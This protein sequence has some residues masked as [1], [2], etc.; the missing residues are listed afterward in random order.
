MRLKAVFA[1]V[2]SALLLVQPIWSQDAPQTAP[3]S[4]DDSTGLFKGAPWWRF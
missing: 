3:R 1:S 4:E 2:L